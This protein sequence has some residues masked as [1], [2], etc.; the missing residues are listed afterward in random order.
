MALRKLFEDIAEL[1]DGV[2]RHGVVV[3]DADSSERAVT[4]DPDATL[5]LGEPDEALV[6]V[7]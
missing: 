1:R 7:R 3:R 5:L 4:R 2:G 6:Q